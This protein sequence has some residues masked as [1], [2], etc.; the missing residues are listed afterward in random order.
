MTWTHSCASRRNKIHSQAP[1][2][3]LYSARGK[4]GCLSKDELPTRRR[5]IPSRA[6]SFLLPAGRS[7]EAQRVAMD[8]RPSAGAAPGALE[9]LGE[10]SDARKKRFEATLPNNRYLQVR[11]YSVVQ[12]SVELTDSPDRPSSSSRCGRNNGSRR[13]RRERSPTRRNR[14]GSTRRRISRER[15]STC[16]QNGSGRSENTRI[17]WIRSSGCVI[18]ALPTS[19][20]PM[21]LTGW[22]IAVSGHDPD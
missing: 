14:C 16:V 1:E 13:S 20:F 9:V 15:A 12:H 2:P 4:D 21:I 11:P 3:I 6:S 22:T 19:P 10:D 18:P 5:L 8:G 7:P 17:T